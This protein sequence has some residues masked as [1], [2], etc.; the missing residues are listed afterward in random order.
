MLHTLQIKTSSRVELIDI[1]EEVRKLVGEENIENGMVCLFVPH[2]TAGLTINEAADPSVKSDIIQKMNSLV[3]VNDGYRHSEG[4]S[5]SHIKCS[6]FGLQ[7]NIIID[8]S[9]LVLGT[10]QGIYFAEFDGPRNRK[11]YIKLMTG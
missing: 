4:N 7:L 9:Q 10:W 3:P 2:T 6:L 11:L 5:D 1:T 8:N